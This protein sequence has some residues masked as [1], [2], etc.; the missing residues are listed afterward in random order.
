MVEAFLLEIYEQAGFAEEVLDRVMVSITEVVN[1]AII[2]GNNSDP[3][4]Y[5]TLTCTCSS[6][7]L[8]FSVRDEGGGFAPDDVPDPLS[9]QNLLKEGGRGLLIIKSMMD[10]VRFVKSAEG[11]EIQ[12]S[13]RCTMA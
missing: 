4:K 9:D 10:D 6:D 11:M 3:G 2:H 8:E 7:K 12:L 13:I 1:N 5:V